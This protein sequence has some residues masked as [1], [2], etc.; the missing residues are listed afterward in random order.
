MQTPINTLL[1]AKDNRLQL[2]SP[3]ITVHDCIMQM[4]EHN[5]GSI[6]VM[7]DDKLVGIFSERDVLKR[8][9]AEQ[10]DP[11]S[12]AVADVMTKGVITI[13]PDTKVEEA[14][15]IMTDRR[16]RHLPVVDNDKLVGLISIGDITRYIVEDQENAI[17]DL[18]GYISGDKTA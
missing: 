18:M 10:L 9:L 16:C 12:T 5:I 4:V 8:V 1:K 11:A 7:E 13:T 15:L 14:M 17:N 3:D 6:L 2:T